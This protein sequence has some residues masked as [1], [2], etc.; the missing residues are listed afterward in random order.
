LEVRDGT[1]AIRFYAGVFGAAEV[2]RGCLLDGHV[3]AVELNLGPYRLELI[4]NPDAGADP[5]GMPLILPC[6]DPEAVLS[7][8]VA[9]GGTVEAPAGDVPGHLVVGVVRDPTGHRIILERLAA[10]VVTGTT[11]VGAEAVPA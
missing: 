9:A 11:A 2:S 5:C 7:R 6:A 3:L 4:E 8:T 1:A 10:P